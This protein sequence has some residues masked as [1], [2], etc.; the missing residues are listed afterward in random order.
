MVRQRNP[1][2]D[3][4]LMQPLFDFL[5]HFFFAMILQLSILRF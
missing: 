5:I 4:F 1:S 2:D 3:P